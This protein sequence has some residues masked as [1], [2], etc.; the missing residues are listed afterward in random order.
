MAPVR[1]ARVVFNEVPAPNTFPEPGKT[2]VYDDSETID[3]DTVPLNGGFLV[4]VLVLSI[5][6]YMRGRMREPHLKPRIYASFRTHNTFT[7]F[8]VGRV[9]RSEHSAVKAGDHI[10]GHMPFQEYAVFADPAY[11]GSDV[12]RVLEN[13]ECLPWSAYVGVCGMPGATAH[14]AWHE[15]AHA[16]PGDTVFVTSAAGPVGSTVVQL[17]KAGGLKVI[18]SAGSDEKV[19]F[20]KSLGADVAFNYK[21][22]DTRAVLAREGGIDIFWDNVGG[23]TLEAAL[24]AAKRFAR[25]IECGM[26]SAYNA[27]GYAPKNLT[28]IVGKEIRLSGFIVGSLY[29][30][31]RDQ[32]Y[33]EIPAL[34]AAGQIK[35]TEDKSVG[36]EAA[37]E[38]IVAVQKGT[39]TG[40]KVIVVADE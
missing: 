16:K 4:K 39:N 10:Y 22:G 7:N 2:T 37:G 24:D 38:A 18:A 32:F 12:F 9:L 26:I 8:A 6:P 35:Y 29:H 31:Y 14:H 13:K 23:E 17:A 21:T 27:E 3:P 40:K 5:D 28:L 30:K 25:F 11:L 34:V 36:L 19:A 33:K 20:V 15:F 1:N